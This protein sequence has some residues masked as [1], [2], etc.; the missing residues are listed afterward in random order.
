MVATLMVGRNKFVASRRLSDSSLSNR[1]TFDVTTHQCSINGGIVTQS[2]MEHR[3]ASPN[4]GDRDGREIH[5]F[6]YT[7]A[8]S[9]FPCVLAGLVGM[10]IRRLHVERPRLSE[11]ARLEY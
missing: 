3:A 4:N 2:A 5:L 8:L 1:A 10:F 6:A 7:P 9:V 11:S